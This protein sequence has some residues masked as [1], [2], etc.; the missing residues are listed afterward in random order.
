MKTIFKLA[1]LILIILSQSACRTHKLTNRQQYR[2]AALELTD[3][4]SR[5][6]QKEFYSLKSTI[7]DSSGQLYQVTIFPADTFEF[8]MQQGFKGKASKVELKGSIRQ[9][10]KLNDSAT[11]S[12]NKERETRSKIIKVH[13]TE[14]VINSKSLENKGFNWLQ[15]CL[16][17]AAAVL[18]A[19]IFPRFRKR[20]FDAMG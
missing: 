1:G 12:A 14:R 13:E 15:L 4:H 17:I 8:S 9:L 7:I 18:I 16:A 11:F 19:M 10:K 2:S 3:T 20:I 6:Q 5:E